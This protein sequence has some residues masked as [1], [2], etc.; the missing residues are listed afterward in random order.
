M[1][2]SETLQEKKPGKWY[3]GGT[4]QQSKVRE[5]KK[6]TKANQLATCADFIAKG[7]KKSTMKGLLSKSTELRAC[8]NEGIG[9]LP[10]TDK[11]RVS[12]IAALCVL[13]LKY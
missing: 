7:Q 11:E 5:W 10:S 4:L 1:V 13:K 2:F 8:I 6:A 12:D 3:E 9:V